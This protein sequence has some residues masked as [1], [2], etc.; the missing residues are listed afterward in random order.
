MGY[1]RRDGV[2]VAGYEVDGRFVAEEEE[3]FALGHVTD[4][5][6][7]MLMWRVGL[8][9][10]PIAEVEDHQHQVIGVNNTAFG[11]C[12]EGGNR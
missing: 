5:F 7:R 6:V 10:G 2:A 12:T 11:A 3:N 8:C 1:V 9:L 4:L